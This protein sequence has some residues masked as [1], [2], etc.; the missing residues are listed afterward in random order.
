MT[1]SEK[2]TGLISE[3][4]SLQNEVATFRESLRAAHARLANAG[5]GGGIRG[6]SAKPREL[7]VAVVV[8]VVAV[9]IAI[10]AVVALASVNG[11]SWYSR[12]CSPRNGHSV[13][14]PERAGRCKVAESNPAFPRTLT[15]LRPTVRDPRGYGV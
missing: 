11:N 6:G 1:P 5:G 14:S 7:V 12:A 2:L 9:V 8:A 10:A 4:P 3:I 13:A 15:G